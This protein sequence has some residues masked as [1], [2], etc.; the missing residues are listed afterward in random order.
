[1]LDVVDVDD[2]DD[3]DDDDDDDEPAVRG[4]TALD[5]TLDDGGAPKVLRGAGTGSGKPEVAP[6]K[7]VLPIS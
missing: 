1:M 7:L 6:M 3:N 2:D 4:K 5:M